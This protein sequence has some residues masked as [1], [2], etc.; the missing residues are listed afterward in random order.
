MRL[1]LDAAV[2]R[3]L[4]P[5]S[6]LGWSCCSA[7]CAAYHQTSELLQERML[8]EMR[9]FEFEDVEPEDDYYQDALAVENVFEEPGYDQNMVEQANDNA[10]PEGTPHDFIGEQD[11]DQVIEEQGHDRNIVE[12]DAL[13]HDP[14][15][16]ELEG[17][18]FIEE[19]GYD[20]KTWWSR[21]TTTHSQYHGYLIHNQITTPFQILGLVTALGSRRTTRSVKS[22]GTTAT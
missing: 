2:S 11:G 14:N 19:Q 10:I 22:R 4:V 13:E 12:F 7:A 6:C 18:Q 15:L 16:A 20:R 17:D 21:A 3:A 8:Q 1:E 5:K 9:T